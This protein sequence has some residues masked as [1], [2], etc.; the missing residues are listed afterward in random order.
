MKHSVTDGRKKALCTPNYSLKSTFF[1]C[2]I[3]GMLAEK[4][5]F[6][7]GILWPEKFIKSLKLSAPRNLNIPWLSE[8][9]SPSSFSECDSVTLHF[10]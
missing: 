7:T 9:S 2:F 6:N 8:L 10:F 3:L 4:T 5:W 1:F